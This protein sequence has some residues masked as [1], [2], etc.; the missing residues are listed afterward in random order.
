LVSIECADILA[1]LGLPVSGASGAHYR[2]LGPDEQRKVDRIHLGL[3]PGRPMTVVSE[4]GLYKLI[5]RS[6]KP[7]ARAFQDWIAR[8]VLP[9]I[10]KTGGLWRVYQKRRFSGVS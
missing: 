10:R 9:A 2:K 6:D 3:R 7:Q 8:D 5:M 1:C 4:S